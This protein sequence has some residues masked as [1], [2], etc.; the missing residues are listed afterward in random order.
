MRV[1]YALVQ[2]AIAFMSDEAGKHWGYELSRGSGVRSGVLY[3]MLS[4]LLDAHWVTDGWETQEEA[5]GRPRRRYYEL[6]DVGRRELG[7]ILE[8]ARLD[9]RFATTFGWA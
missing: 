1:T 2:V 8:G 6:T 9:P 3:P 5:R 4:R 7:A